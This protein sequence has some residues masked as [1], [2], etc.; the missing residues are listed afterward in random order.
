MNPNQCPI[1]PILDKVLIIAEDPK[2]TTKGGI[3]LA[4]NTKKEQ[5]LIATVVARGPGGMI[6]GKEVK[7]YVNPGDRVLVNEYSG[8]KINYENKEY[9]IVRQPE[10]LGTVN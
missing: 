10:I 7:M 5:P 3:I 8:T 4:G 6:D 9:I 2:E 1:Q